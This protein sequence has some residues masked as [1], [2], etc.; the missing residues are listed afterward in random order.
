MKIKT[1]TILMFAILVILTGC[2]NL[3]QDSFLAKNDIVNAFM[4]RIF[5]STYATESIN[6]GTGVV[7]NIVDI[8]CL[9]GLSECGPRQLQM[10]NAAKIAVN[11]VFGD[12]IPKEALVSEIRYIEFTNVQA[13]DFGMLADAND[14]PSYNENKCPDS[15]KY[16]VWVNGPTD[17]SPQSCYNQTYVA[18]DAK[19]WKIFYSETTKKCQWQLIDDVKYPRDTWGKPVQNVEYINAES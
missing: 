7:E 6:D 11:H 16:F 19:S 9:K 4:P 10:E 5:S 13:C 12:D 15:F 2:V 14:F 3:G 17:S 8:S 18:M 1:S